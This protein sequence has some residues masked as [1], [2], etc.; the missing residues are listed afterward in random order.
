MCHGETEGKKFP[1]ESLCKWPNL[2]NH[3]EKWEAAAAITYLM[4]R[5]GVRGAGGSLTKPSNCFVRALST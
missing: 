3:G 2:L 1:P 4:S 5:S